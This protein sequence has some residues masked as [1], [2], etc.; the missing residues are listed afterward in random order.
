MNGQ[1]ITHFRNILM[2]L[3]GCLEKAAAHADTKKIDLEVLTNYRLAPDMFSLL[4]QIQ[5]ACD[6][7]KFCA[8]YLTEQ[9][10]PVHEDTETTWIEMRERLKKVINYLETFNESSFAKAETVV[11]KPKWAKG[12]WTTGANYMN[13]ISVPNFY[14]H[15]TMVYAILRHAG[16]DLGKMDFLGQIKLEE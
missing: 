7:A 15:A 6:A 3:D 16:V 2:N 12:K 5:S 14:F 8:A 13:Q 9:T 1:T 4:K 10:A 11:V